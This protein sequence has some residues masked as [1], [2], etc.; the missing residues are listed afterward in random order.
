MP[1]FIESYSSIIIFDV[2]LMVALGAIVPHERYRML[3]AEVTD[4]NRDLCLRLQAYW[5][6]T[7]LVSNPNPG[8]NP[9]TVEQLIGN[10]FTYRGT[11]ESGDPLILF[12]HGDIWRDYVRYYM[13]PA[14][15]V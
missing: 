13:L 14:M 9:Y 1:P 5:A 4:G 6:T 12:T 10:Y 11:D 2:H 15:S 3:D 7:I 8:Y